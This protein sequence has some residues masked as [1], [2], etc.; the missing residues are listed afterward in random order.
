MWIGAIV[1]FAFKRVLWRENLGKKKMYVFFSQFG[2]S[3]AAR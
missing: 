3:A 2:Q 1:L